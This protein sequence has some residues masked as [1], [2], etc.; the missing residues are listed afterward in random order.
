MRVTPMHVEAYSGLRERVAARLAAGAGAN[1]RA[2]DERTPLH[3]AAARD[4]S[5]IA[6]LLLEHGADVHAREDPNGR[7]PLHDAAS[8]DA[9]AT[10]A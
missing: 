8:R 3:Y 9:P 4:R 2:D 5:Q 1:V 6:R 10:L 7:T